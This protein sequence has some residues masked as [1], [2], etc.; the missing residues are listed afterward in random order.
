MHRAIPMVSKDCYFGY[1]FGFVKGGNLVIGKGTSFADD[2]VVASW[3]GKENAS[4][5]DA[6]ISI[7][8]NCSFN[9]FNHITAI[10]KVQI[11][12]GVMTG[13]YVVITDN[14]HGILSLDMAEIPVKKRPL[15]SKGPI[16]IGN[17]VWLGDKVAVMPNVKIGNNVIVGANSVVTHDLPDNCMAAG[18]PA[19]IIK[20]L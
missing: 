1:P 10:N 17:N 8:E 4:I 3:K 18:A 11:G 6:Q 2:C 7:G 14:S 12:N 16:I 5:D 19:K 20:R 15:V 9:R 13:M